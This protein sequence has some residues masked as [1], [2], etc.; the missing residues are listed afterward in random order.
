MAIVVS[1]ARPCIRRRAAAATVYRRGRPAAGTVD[2]RY[3]WAAATACRP[4]PAA[5]AA[6]GRRDRWAAS[7]SRSTTGRAPDAARGPVVPLPPVRPSSARNPRSPQRRA[8]LPRNVS[9]RFLFSKDGVLHGIGRFRSA[10]VPRIIEYDSGHNRGIH[11]DARTAVTATVEYGIVNPPPISSIAAPTPS[12][13]CSTTSG[14][15]CVNDP[16]V[17]I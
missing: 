17:G 3:R 5:A 14:G 11:R 15:A 9:Y 8:V 6:A 7:G 13:T 16:W 10:R 4:H 12:R 1:A 2:R